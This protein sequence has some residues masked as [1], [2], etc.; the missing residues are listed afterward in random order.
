MVQLTTEQRIS[1]TNM[2][3]HPVNQIEVTVPAMTNLEY[4][5]G[6]QSAFVIHRQTSL[7]Y[8]NLRKI[9]TLVKSLLLSPQRTLDLEYQDGDDELQ[10]LIAEIAEMCDSRV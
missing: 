3:T 1:I 7:F 8:R 2:T 6:G 5:N 10:N 9:K 4:Q